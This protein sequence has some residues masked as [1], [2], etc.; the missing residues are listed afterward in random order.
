MKGCLRI[1]RAMKLLTL[2]L[3]LALA[4]PAWAQ[5]SRPVGTE[6]YGILAQLFTYDASLPLNARVIPQ[7]DSAGYAREKIVFDGWRGAR[8]PGLV[9]IPKDS[10][11]RHAVIVLIDGI[12]G[13]KERWWQ[14]TSWNRG[15]ILIDSLL[16]AGF[17][18]AM[19]DAFASGERT[20]A[21]DYE[22]AETFIRKF[23]QLRD[24]ALQNTIEHRRLID[25]LSSRSDID[26]TR[27]GAL[28]LS[29]GGMT[30]FYL[31]AFE[32]RVRAGVAGLTPAQRIPDLL[33]P[34]HY[35][36]HVRMP[37]LMLMGRTDAFYTQQQVA[38]IFASLGSKEKQLQWYDV[39]HRLPEAYAGAAVAWFRQF[40]R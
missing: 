33:W 34:G 40:L 24:M 17:A 19:I 35:A 27:I 7:F 6:G 12:G 9:A 2:L 38:A 32:P 5:D 39:G 22:T 16:A 8:V 30:T 4:T 25:Y 26:S 15:R 31:G 21:N 36:A 20:F 13:W 28:G 37:L 1:L 23:S 29:L 3:G 18:V 11:P 14:E 10:Q